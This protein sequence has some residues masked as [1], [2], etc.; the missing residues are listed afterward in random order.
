[1]KTKA[2][3]TSHA[4][5]SARR[6]TQEERILEHIKFLPQTL[7]S[8]HELTGIDKST[9]AARLSALQ[10]RGIVTGFETTQENTL[11]RQIIT[12]TVYDYEPDPYRRIDHAHSR[13]R[14]LAI[15]RIESSL[16]NDL[17]FLPQ[18]LV[19]NMRAFLEAEKAAGHLSKDYQQPCNKPCGPSDYYRGG[20]CDEN[21]CYNEPEAHRPPDKF[22]PL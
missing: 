8:L 2:S 21:G 5:R 17:E 13:R 14:N 19:A 4:P 6:F 9:I 22:K 10:E 20:K 3:T 12:V 18:A 1:M 7:K 15:A 11:R 16:K